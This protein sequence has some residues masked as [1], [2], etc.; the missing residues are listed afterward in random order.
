N[1]DK[2]NV[3]LMLG[4][5]GSVDIYAGKVERAPQFWQKTGLEWFYRM[6]KQPKRAKRILGSLPP[7]M[8]AVYKEKRAERKAAR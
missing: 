8:L 6:M 2:L 3:S 7:F 4:L 1:R 5:G